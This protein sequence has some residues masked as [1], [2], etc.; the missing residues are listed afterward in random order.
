MSLW[1]QFQASLSSQKH[2]QAKINQQNKIKQ[3]LNNKGKIFYA[4]KNF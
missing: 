2:S 1:G 3:K 4:R